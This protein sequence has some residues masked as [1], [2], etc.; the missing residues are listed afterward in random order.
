MKGSSELRFPAERDLKALVKQ[1]ESGSTPTEEASG[2]DRLCC[3]CDKEFDVR[4][5]P[6]GHTV[7]CLDCSTMAKRCPTCNVSYPHCNC[8]CGIFCY[9]FAGPN[10]KQRT[11]ELA[12]LNSVVYCVA[13]EVC[14]VWCGLSC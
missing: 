6:C 9:N 3:M 13:S 2:E 14:V 5:Q 12:V 1:P 10:S 7:L 11:F 4:L 8:A